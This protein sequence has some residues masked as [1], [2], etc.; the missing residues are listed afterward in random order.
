MIAPVASIGAI[1]VFY[2]ITATG[3]ADLRQV[4]P[5]P[6]TRAMLVPHLF[7]LPQPL[8]PVEHFCQTNSIALIEDCAH[9]FFGSAGSAPIGRTGDFAIG[10]LP[11]F[12]PV[13]EGGLLASAKRSI[14]SGRLAAR[15]VR[16]ETRAI[17]DMIDLAAQAGRLGLTG[18]A[19]R[20]AKSARH[21]MRL[22]QGTLDEQSDSKPADDVRES[23]LS[24]PLLSPARCCA[25]EAWV[26]T[27]SNLGVNVSARRR[28]YLHLK[29]AFDA[30]GLAATA[31]IE[32]R[33]DHAPYVL[34]L[35]IQDADAAYQRMREALLPVF[36]WDRLWP[37]SQ[38]LAGDTARTWSS[39]LIQ[40]ACHQS[41]TPSDVD[42][43][44]AS[45]IQALCNGAASHR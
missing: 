44:V 39:N 2:P 29:R 28:N 18:R 34:P 43:I 35:I 7:G 6:R 5:T 4:R 17:W 19:I 10:S 25:S 37:G 15:S 40:V 3:T 32:L 38:S 21:S 1:P 13:T 31:E 22:R 24:D 9:S 36:R 42:V 27:H 8:G 11:K 14:P 12:F 20:G 16:H 45:G 23:S 33:V 41:L 30:S 26:V